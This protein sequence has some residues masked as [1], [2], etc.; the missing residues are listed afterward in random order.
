MVSSGNPTFRSCRTPFAPS[1]PDSPCLHHPPTLRTT[2]RER[3]SALL[4]ATFARTSPTP[5]LPPSLPPISLFLHTPSIPASPPSQPRLLPF[6]LTRSSLSPSSRDPPPPIPET[7]NAHHVAVLALTPLHL[8]SCTAPGMSRS[9]T[10]AYRSP[11][12]GFEYR[13]RKRI[14]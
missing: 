10:R 3:Y 9:C 7:G 4:A 1:V 2:S 11:R 6:T 8:A 13:S 5:S 14:G 12:R